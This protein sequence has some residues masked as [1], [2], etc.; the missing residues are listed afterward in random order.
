M[1]VIYCRPSSIVQ[2]NGY[3]LHLRSKKR[4]LFWTLHSTDVPGTGN[5][6]T[7]FCAVVIRCLT[8]P[9]WLRYQRQSFQRFQAF[10]RLKLWHLAVHWLSPR[11]RRCVPL[12]RCSP[13]RGYMLQI[14]TFYHRFGC[15][16]RHL[17]VKHL[18]AVPTPIFLGFSRKGTDQTIQAK[19]GSGPPPYH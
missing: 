18:P 7:A 8:G 1:T 9:L 14:H 6:T 13:L 19:P 17:A 5:H 15:T 16:L 10:G 4:Q 12:C 11:Y 2:I 3:P